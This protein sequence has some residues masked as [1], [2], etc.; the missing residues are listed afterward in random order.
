MKNEILD[1]EDEQDKSPHSTRSFY[2][3]LYSFAVIV[4]LSLFAIFFALTF[5]KSAIFETLLFFLGFSAFISNLLGVVN[6]IKS[7]RKKEDFNWKTFIGGMGNLV[8]F[9]FFLYLILVLI[10]DIIN[11]FV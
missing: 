4:G 5:A 1:A 3:F 2:Y 11:V 8:L 6:T 10:V 7:S 9:I